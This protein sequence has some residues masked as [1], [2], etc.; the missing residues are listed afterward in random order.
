MT[1]I[2]HHD[3]L[4]RAITLHRAENPR[5]RWETL[6][7]RD[8]TTWMDRALADLETDHPAD[9]APA[10]AVGL[11]ERDRLILEIA[12]RTFRHFGARERVIR[13]RLGMTPRTF[14]VRLNAL[15]DMPEALEVAPATVHRL[16][17]L[18]TSARD[19]DDEDEGR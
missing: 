10:L 13:V 18:R 3:I 11:S 4:T 19:H 1:T 8:R 15:L 17:A 9:D 14:L 16:R 7:T 2:P 5:T 12:G 6:T